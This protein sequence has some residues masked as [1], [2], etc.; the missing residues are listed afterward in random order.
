MRFAETPREI[1][2]ADGNLSEMD[3]ITHMAKILIEIGGHQE[4]AILQ[5]A[6]QQNHEIILGMLWPKGH[7]PK[8]DRENE[9]IPFDS[10]RCITWCLGQSATI[11]AVQETKA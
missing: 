7:N 3:P 9:K 11:Y 4:I 8:I 10:E 6:N 1:Y 5:V 2:M